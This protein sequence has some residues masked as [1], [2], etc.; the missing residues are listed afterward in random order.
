MMEDWNSGRMGFKSEKYPFEYN[1][2]PFYPIFQLG[3]SLYVS[4]MDLYEWTY[5][6]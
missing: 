5:E 4:I 2:T 3:R 6:N 1:Y